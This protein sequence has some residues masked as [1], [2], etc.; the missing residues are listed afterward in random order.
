MFKMKALVVNGR[1]EE[2]RALVEALA[3]IP[4]VAVQ[5][6]LSD[7]ETAT[8]VLAR[9]TP[10]LLVVGTELADGDGIRLVERAR[11]RGMAIVVV[12]PAPSRD[13]W[14]RYLLAGAD[15]FVEPDRELEELT[16]VVRELVRRAAGGRLEV[17]PLASDPIAAGIATELNES[18]HVIEAALELLERSPGD[19]HL[20][21]ESRAALEQVVCLAGMLLGQVSGH[22][23][24]AVALA[25]TPVP[26]PRG[27][28]S[29]PPAARTST[30][31]GDVTGTGAASSDGGGERIAAPR[32]PHS[33]CS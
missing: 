16:E 31:A 24:P 14:R 21:S 20:W 3:R 23:P 8:R 5:C 10:D 13:V 1:T 17:P 15:R 12:G 22:D 19:R 27:R 2:R 25:S 7:L 26:A 29:I 11:R 33:P 18:L 9:V 6:A 28:A 4:E 30:G 32:G